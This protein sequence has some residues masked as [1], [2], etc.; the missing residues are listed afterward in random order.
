MPVI[1]ELGR[2]RMEA[3]VTVKS[4][5]G[6]KMFALSV[7]VLVPV[8]DNTAKA[9]IRVTTGKAKYDATKRA[10]VSTAPV[11]WDTVSAAAAAAWPGW[12]ATAVPPAGTG[13]AHLRATG[14]RRV[15]SLG[16][17]GRHFRDCCARC[18]L[19][20]PWHLT[21]TNE[22]KGLRACGTLQP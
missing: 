3:N 9:I 13:A 1:K 14:R 15:E 7:V 5:F 19:Q 12:A 11:A 6:P 2:T 4:L 17:G 10:I 8:P 18:S 21:L 20:R 22:I 16:D